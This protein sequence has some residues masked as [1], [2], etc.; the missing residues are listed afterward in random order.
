V[1]YTPVGG[2]RNVTGAGDSG[3]ANA[4]WTL[5]TSNIDPCGYT[6]RVRAFKRTIFDSATWYFHYVDKY[7]GFSIV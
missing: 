1:V 6:V 7:V 4:A 2:A 5:G 3:D